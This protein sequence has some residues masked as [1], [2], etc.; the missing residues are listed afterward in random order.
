MLIDH[1]YSVPWRE[2]KFEQAAE[3]GG[4]LK[5]LF[6]HNEMI[7]PRRAGAHGGDGRSPDPAFSP[8]QYDRI[9]LLYTIASVRAGQWLIPAFHAAI[10]S[11]IANGHDD[12]LNFNIESFANSLDK[13]IDRLGR[14]EETEPVPPSADATSTDVANAAPG[15]SSSD[16]PATALLSTPQTDATSKPEPPN[17]IVTPPKSRI[18]TRPRIPHMTRKPTAPNSA[19]RASLKAIA[20]AFARLIAPKGTRAEDT[21]DRWIVTFQAKATSRGIAEATYTRVMR[22]IHPDTAGLDAIGQQPECR[23]RAS[24]PVAPG[25]MNWPVNW[26]A[27]RLVNWLPIRLDEAPALKP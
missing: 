21:F 5:G 22:G 9:A 25:D 11:N 1:D 20:G 4:A 16:A 18:R 19:K 26:R 10:D 7:Q 8:A 12:P 24:R 6:L 13:L 2:T 27:N 17:V 3:F 14:P 15:A 23:R